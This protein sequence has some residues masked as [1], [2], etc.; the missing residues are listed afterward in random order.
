MPD[1]WLVQVQTRIEKLAALDPSMGGNVCASAVGECQSRAE[2]VKLDNL[3][4]KAAEKEQRAAEKE[5]DK[6][7]R[8]REREEFKRQ[9]EEERAREK[10]RKE[11]EREAQRQQKLFEAAEALR[12]KEI[13][14]AK[15]APKIGGI[16]AKVAKKEPS[17]PA[18]DQ[19]QL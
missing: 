13:E 9:K 19:V 7:Q 3:R 17:S 2:Q 15:L 6:L 16:F 11:L 4:A 18:Q 8:D 10:E 5:A 1:C 12:L 14:D